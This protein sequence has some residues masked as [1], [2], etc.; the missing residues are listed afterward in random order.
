MTS[1]K[2]VKN[3]SDTQKLWRVSPKEGSLRFSYVVSSYSEMAKETMVFAANRDGEVLDWIDLACI[4]DEQPK[5]DEVIN[6]FNKLLS[7]II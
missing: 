2:Y 5:H 1:T 4:K 6:E 3:V 7:I